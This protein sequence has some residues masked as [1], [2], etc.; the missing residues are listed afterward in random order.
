[1]DS[2]IM[3]MNREFIDN[4][5]AAHDGP[6]TKAA[7][8]GSEFTRRKVR[9][10]DFSGQILPYEDVT[11]D[12]LNQR[13]DSE[14]PSII[15]E[16]ESDQFGAVSIAPN[17]SGETK[18][19]WGDKY[20][21]T[22]HTNATPVW[23]KNINKLRTYRMD[24][25]QVISDNSLRDLS[26]RKSINFMAYVDEIIG[27]VDGGRS[28]I[29]G[30]YQSILYPGGLDRSNMIN[31]IRLLP[32]TQ[33]PNGVFLTN[34]MTFTELLKWDRNQMGGEFAQETVLEGTG[35]FKTAKFAGVKFIVTLMNDI[36]PNGSIYEFTQPKFLGRAAT[37]EAP[38]MYVEKKIDMISFHC[39]EMVGFAIGNMNGIRKV[40]FQDIANSTGGDGRIIVD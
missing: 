38:T 9:E 21:L 18:F 23:T 24:L 13:L 7:S 32:A 34:Y 39:R 8:W 36:V 2:E 31:S 11:N 12:D 29:T 19:F 14:D 40:T 27:L 6:I 4:V 22:F 10:D 5:T 17:D 3:K 30:Q 25:R 1:M 35:A 20:L 33:L 37:L 26:R 16:M 15:C 28:P